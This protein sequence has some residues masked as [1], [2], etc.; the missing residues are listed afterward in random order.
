[1]ILAL[2]AS[3]VHF[4]ARPHVLSW[5]LTVVWFE[6]LDSAASAPASAQ[7]KRLFWLPVVMLLWV[8]VH[9]GFLLGFVLLAVYLAGGAIEYCSR[10]RAA[11]AKSQPG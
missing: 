5:L 8:N 4:L 11:R 10:S 6:L 7:K 1:M 3:A 9:G 2:A